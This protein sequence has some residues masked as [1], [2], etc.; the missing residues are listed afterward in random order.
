MAAAQLEGGPVVAPHQAAVGPDQVV[1]QVFA[2]PA[3]AVGHGLATQEGSGQIDGD[4][5]LPFR[6]GQFE[7][8]H[9]L[10][11]PGTVH[12]HMQ[13]AQR[14]HGLRDHRL[15]G[16]RISHVN[17]NSDGLSSKILYFRYGGFSA[18]HTDIS[19]ADISAFAGKGQTLFGLRPRQLL[20]AEQNCRGRSAD[21]Q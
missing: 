7:K 5:T 1:E 14:G 11:Y 10:P 2:R 20:A 16:S 8:R 17:L 12:E 4:D 6:E 3:A 18:L 19:N 21:D 9:D 13:S 15:H